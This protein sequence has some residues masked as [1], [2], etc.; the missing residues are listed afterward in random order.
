MKRS[1]KSFVVRSSLL[2]AA[3]LVAFAAASAH[4]AAITWGAAVTIGTNGDSDVLNTGSTLY[5]Y[6]FSSAQTVHSVNFVYATGTYSGANIYTIGSDITLSDSTRA[7]TINTSA[8]SHASG[9]TTA[10]GT[11]LQG[12]IY[13]SPVQTITVS[14][15]NLVSGKNYAV[16]VWAEDSRATI[17]RKDT[18]TSTGG[19]SVILNFN[20]TSGTGGAGQYTIGTFTASGTTQDFTILGDVSSQLNAIQVRDLGVAS[21]PTPAALPAGLGLLAFAATRRRRR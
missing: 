10:Y 20:A 12:A 17:N 19:N 4:A 9:L 18:L 1:I 8:Y 13:N 16:Q 5:A 6:D 11:M 2:A 7:L 21:V 14:L 15:K 3:L